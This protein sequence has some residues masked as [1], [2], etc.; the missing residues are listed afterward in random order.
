MRSTWVLSRPGDGLRSVYRQG[1]R[2]VHV[3]SAV[4][5]TPGGVGLIDLGYIGGLTAFGGEEKAAIVA[6][7]LLFRALTY[8]IQI[9]IGRVHL[10]H[11]AGQVGLAPSGGRGGAARTRWLLRDLRERKKRFG[12]DPGLRGHRGRPARYRAHREASARVRRRHPGRRPGRADGCARPRAVRR[13]RPRHR[14]HHLRAGRGSPAP[15][16]AWPSPRSPDPRSW[17]P[18]RPCSSPCRS[19]A[20]AVERNGASTILTQKPRAS[21]RRPRARRRLGISSRT[22]PTSG[23]SGVRRKPDRSPRRRCHALHSKPRVQ[24]TPTIRPGP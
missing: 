3:L 11:L 6:A 23:R 18:H 24:V 9:P 5:V 20:L 19:E 15:S 4:P 1:V 12:A 13:G 8:A 14:I 21:C 22:R 10:H 16:T 17:L 2:G 7:V